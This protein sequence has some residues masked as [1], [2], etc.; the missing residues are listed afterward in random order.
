V[1]TTGSGIGMIFIEPDAEIVA[2]VPGFG[3]ATL[4]FSAG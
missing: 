4:A 1:I 3:S 2:E